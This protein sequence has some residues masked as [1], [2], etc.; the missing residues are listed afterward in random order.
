MSV[1]YMLKLE[2]EPE[3]YEKFFTALTNSANK[4]V[5]NWIL[6]RINPGMEVLEVGCG[7][8]VLSRKISQKKAKILAYDKNL[9][10]IMHA[11]K[12]LDPVFK[13]YIK[14]Q[15]GSAIDLPEDLGKFDCIITTFMLSELR[16]LE[17]QIFLRYA[18]A[19]LK[20]DGRLII[21]DEFVP[22]GIA[23]IWFSLKRLWYK[24]KLKRIRT[25]FTHPLKFILRYLEP[26]GFEIKAKDCWAHGSIR[27]FE[28]QKKVDA[29]AGFYRPLPH[30]FRG[31]KARARAVRCLLTGQIDHVAIEPGIYQSGSPT[32]QSPIIVTTNYEYT[33]F[34]VMNDLKGIDAW[35]LCVDSNGINVWCAARGGNFGNTQLIEA[36]RATGIQH[37]VDHRL[38]I[39]PQLAAGGIAIPQL[40]QTFLFKIRY[41]PIWSKYLK[42]YLKT[43][44]S[45]KP[46]DM[47]VAKFN[48]KKRLEAGVTHATFLLRKFVLIP[49]ILLTLAL[50]ILF[51][52]NLFFLQPIYLQ[53]LETVGWIFLSILITNMVIAL[54]FPLVDFTRSFIKKGFYLGAVSSL[55]SMVLFWVFFQSLM[56]SIAN[57]IYSFW[58]GYFSTMSFSGYTM[59]SS[60]REI[61]A[62][63]PKF[64]KINKLL[65]IVMLI[66][67]ISIIFIEIFTQV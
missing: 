59:A 33:Y 23:R 44:P 31:I 47:R 3:T 41:G 1:T 39:L 12:S 46:E 64:T 2:E 29:Q 25:G 40:P 35:V 56:L 11:M 5:Q 66:S 13:D 8:G 15:M 67:I 42:S 18:W 20:P 14:F 49:A 16:P 34:K 51:I 17:Q 28:C 22:N 9:N 7:P 32:R 43:M 30:L 21:A 55:V 48:F 27:V 60:P 6:D 53:L 36:V 10:M 26:I 45:R 38:L 62:E 19:H 61:K 63:Y 37:L 52:I 54:I 57:L 65:I 4:K 24:R 58:I 50:V